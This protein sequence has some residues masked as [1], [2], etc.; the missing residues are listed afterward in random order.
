MATVGVGVIGAGRMGATHVRL[1]HRSVSGARVA[2]L[3]DVVHDSA[4]RLAAEEAVPAVHDDPLDLVR[5]PAVDAVV[6]ASADDSHEALVLA[7]LQAGKPV[8]CEKPLA[9]TAQASLRIVEAE[10]AGGRRLVQVGF[11]RRYDPGYVDMKRRLEEGEIG[12]PLLLHCA[13]R[14]PAA[15]SADRSEHLIVS[16]LVHE[17]DVAR[18]LLGEE[19]AR[20][21]VFLPRPSRNAA[22][23]IRDPQFAVLETADGRLVDVEVFVNAGY[24]YDIR[25]TLV[26][27]TGALELPVAVTPGFEERFEAAYLAELR[28]WTG[29]RGGGATAWDGYAAAAVAEACIESLRS[30]RSAAVDL[31]A[32]GREAAGIEAG[33]HAIRFYR[34]DAPAAE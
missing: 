32:P 29:G 30:G 15:Y 11:M 8:L 17:I 28:A 34:G 7:C 20:T 18:W 3:S 22:A 1:L 25:C 4:A 31:R 27:E 12:A 24:G 6:V 23:G 9:P 10:L 33:L 14:N 2:A 19:I 21:T 13:H 26:G 5:D 16:S